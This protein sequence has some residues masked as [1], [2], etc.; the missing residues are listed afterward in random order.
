MPTES[1]LPRIDIPNTDLWGFLFER[2]D[3]PYPDDKSDRISVL[4][5]LTIS[6]LI[7]PQ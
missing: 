2:N 6:L 5:G 4:H 7:Y 3:R 1:L